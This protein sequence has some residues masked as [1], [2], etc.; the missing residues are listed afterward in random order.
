[1]STG[2]DMLGMDREVNAIAALLTSRLVQPPLSIALLGPAA[3]GKSFFLRR[4]WESVRRIAQGAR[5]VHPENTRSCR[6]VLQYQYNAWEHDGANQWLAIADGI[7]GAYQEWSSSVGA[8]STGS[9]LR[10]PTAEKLRAGLVAQVHSAEAVLENAAAALHAAEASFEDSVAEQA[11]QTAFD[12]WGEITRRFKLSLQGHENAKAIDQAGNLLGLPNLSDD[13]QQIDQLYQQS[14]TLTGRANL[15]ASSLKTRRYLGNVFLGVLGAALLSLFLFFLIS[16]GAR[17][18]DAPQFLEQM[19]KSLA[20]IAGL[21]TVIG[22]WFGFFLRNQANQA[23][24]RLYKFQPLL[25]T[26]A[27]D[28]DREL[29]KDTAISDARLGAQRKQLDA[30]L[31][32]LADAKNAVSVAEQELAE[33]DARGPLANVRDHYRKDVLTSGDT[34]RPSI[35]PILRADLAALSES[36]RRRGDVSEPAVGDSLDR[37]V[38]YVEDLDYCKAETVVNVLQAIHLLLSFDLFAVV[39]AADSRWLMYCLDARYP[40]AAAL[41]ETSPSDTTKTAV[42]TL[43]K[44]IQIPF[45][46]EPFAPRQGAAAMIRAQSDFRARAPAPTIEPAETI[47]LGAAEVHVE[48]PAIE[49]TLTAAEIQFMMRVVVPL[50][51]TPRRIKKL[52]NCYRLLRAMLAP[53]ELDNFLSEDPGKSDYHA[54]L[55]LLAAISATPEVAPDLRRWI[56]E[57]ASYDVNSLR[58]EEGDWLEDSRQRVRALLQDYLNTGDARAAKEKLRR[59]SPH[60]FRFSLLSAAAP[61]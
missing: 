48:S 26:I 27:R 15:L 5:E 28:L 61:N 19:S 55:T 24:D 29:A 4:T 14:N 8:G 44:L 34:L 6:N 37:I 57:D 40:R 12:R 20:G 23:L 54:V 35:V 25:R 41:L 18:N 1:M 31:S 9:S 45:W 30:S 52:V 43:E 10:M 16:L 47:V 21:L 56:E 22:L 33:F 2:P 11:R 58:G 3:S 59:W 32:R 13:A 7:L 17:T 50:N 39:L 46:L 42:E 53:S 60:V 38:V 36:T 51:S 49:N